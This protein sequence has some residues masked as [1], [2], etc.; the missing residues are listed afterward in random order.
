[1]T[2]SINDIQ[3]NDTQLKELICDVQL[4][5]HSAQMTLSIMAF[6]IECCYA[7]RIMLNV[8]IYSLL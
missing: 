6:D 7:E 8:S 5:W 2:L 3:Q 1:V 4:K